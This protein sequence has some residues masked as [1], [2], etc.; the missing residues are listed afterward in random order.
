MEKRE[1]QLI[2]RILGKE[3]LNAAKEYGKQ[4]KVAVAIQGASPNVQTAMER[5]ASVA[6]A[7]GAE[8][9]RS[10]L[11][12]PLAKK[13]PKLNTPVLCKGESNVLFI[14]EFVKTAD[15][16]I[17]SKDMNHCPTERVEYWMEIPNSEIRA[18]KEVAMN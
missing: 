2:E 13:Y 12:H 10:S 11:W 17:K 18:T 7:K 1:E 16:G 15:G 6:F 4:I 8:N 9:F 3:F 5:I 14:A